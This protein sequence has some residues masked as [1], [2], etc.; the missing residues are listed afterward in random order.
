[1]NVDNDKTPGPSKQTMQS[2]KE[3]PLPNKPQVSR[4]RPV[5][6][7]IK[8]VDERKEN[9]GPL[10]GGSN[11]MRNDDRASAGLGPMTSGTMQSDLRGSQSLSEASKGFVGTG[12]N[13][14]VAGQ[15]TAGANQSSLWSMEN[16][17]GILGLSKLNNDNAKQPS[18]VDANAM[19]SKPSFVN[20][21]PGMQAP[22]NSAQG[23]QIASKPSVENTGL[24][25]HVPAGSTSNQKLTGPQVNGFKVSTSEP[26]PKVPMLI[27]ITFPKFLQTKNDSMIQIMV[28]DDK[29][30]DKGKAVMPQ[31][32]NFKPV[33]NFTG[34]TG[35]ILTASEEFF[36]DKEDRTDR[37]NEGK[38]I[39]Q[40]AKFIDSS[41][42]KL[43]YQMSDFV[44]DNTQTPEQQLKSDHVK[45]TAKSDRIDNKENSA[46][47]I[48][49]EETAPPKLM[50]EDR[51]GKDNKNKDDSET[52]LKIAK[53]LMHNGDPASNDD[54]FIPKQL[55]SDGTSTY[56]RERNEPDYGFTD[57][58]IKVNNTYKSHDSGVLSTR[59]ITN[60]G[61]LSAI[62]SPIFGNNTSV[63]FKPDNFKLL[64]TNSSVLVPMH[65]LNVSAGNQ[66]LKLPNPADDKQSFRPEF[67]NESSP[68]DA[69]MSYENS[70][71]QKLENS[72][73][74]G[75][76]A[77]FRPEVESNDIGSK[78]FTTIN[79]K[80][81][82]KEDKNSTLINRIV[83]NTNPGGTSNEKSGPL[84]NGDKLEPVEEKHL[85]S[86]EFRGHKLENDWEIKP[87]SSEDYGHK[88]K[89]ESHDEYQN[90]INNKKF[91]KLIDFAEIADHSIEKK[92]QHHGRVSDSKFVNLE[93]QILAQEDNIFKKRPVAK[94]TQQERKLKESKGLNGPGSNSERDEG[95][96]EKSKEAEFSFSS[97]IEEHHKLGLHGVELLPDRNGGK[98]T[99]D[100][101]KSG[102]NHEEESSEFISPKEEKESKSVGSSPTKM[103]D[104]KLSD[105]VERGTHFAATSQKTLGRLDNE[106]LGSQEVVGLEN[107][108]RS[109]HGV[110]K[111]NSGNNRLYLP[112]NASSKQNGPSAKLEQEGVQAS[113]SKSTEHRE[114]VGYQVQSNDVG[115]VD[116]ISGGKSEGREQSK[117][118]VSDRQNHNSPAGN[119]PAQDGAK[120]NND[121]TEFNSPE[122]NNQKSFDSGSEKET[123]PNEHQS[124][125]NSLAYDKTSNVAENDVEG[126]V[127]KV[128]QKL[129]SFHNVRVS[130]NK[131]VKENDNITT[132]SVGNGFIN[133]RY[134]KP[135]L[136]RND[137]QEAKFYSHVSASNSEFAKPV[138]NR[139][140]S[141]IN[142][143]I[144]DTEDLIAS[145]KG[146]PNIENEERTGLRE[147]QES[148]LV[149]V[150]GEKSGHKSFSPVI[151][152][153]N[154]H[155]F[156]IQI[157]PTHSFH[158][159]SSDKKEKQNDSGEHDTNSQSSSENVVL[160]RQAMGKSKSVKFLNKEKDSNSHES[161]FSSTKERTSKSQEG[162]TASQDDSQIDL[163]KA[164]AQ[165]NEKGIKASQATSDRTVS[166]FNDGQ[167]NT[168]TLSNADTNTKEPTL[169][170]YKGSSSSGNNGHSILEFTNK[171]LKSQGV[172]QALESNK[173][174]GENQFGTG[175][176]EH[177]GFH[178]RQESDKFTKLSGSETSQNGLNI[179]THGTENSYDKSLKT[180]G[181]TN[182]PSSQHSGNIQVSKS[183]QDHSGSN[184][185]GRTGSRI[186]TKYDDSDFIKDS[187]NNELEKTSN[188]DHKASNMLTREGFSRGRSKDIGTESKHG[189]NTAGHLLTGSL[190]ENH[191]SLESRKGKTDAKTDMP[192]CKSNCPKSGSSIFNP[193]KIARGEASVVGLNLQAGFD[194]FLGFS[195]MKSG[196]ALSKTDEVGA[197]SRQHLE[198]RVNEHSSFGNE[199]IFIPQEGK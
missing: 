23:M 157:R 120:K 171:Q 188:E 102:R 165:S 104:Q 6:P 71:H 68:Q 114:Q 36:N 47:L 26:T 7:E 139:F 154:D 155:H 87:A 25:M 83:T 8:K 58:T 130:G 1:M 193:E 195:K 88:N 150:H 94:M 136:H 117:F 127:D 183:Q 105:S 76:P 198:G 142:P 138:V 53:K 166:R 12:Q 153:E 106:H 192:I 39:E 177:L 55:E 54:Y 133:I 61:N 99:E 16:V 124:N 90:V 24:G 191:H 194:R 173:G 170:P 67:H 11:Y 95:N 92:K 73:K 176:Y 19:A 121:G 184:L 168:K 100:N 37:L 69:L 147:T 143:G 160:D 72:L 97:S 38:S 116:K 40:P 182:L 162:T 151:D 110:T 163:M 103:V 45:G 41:D 70:P 141:Q 158:G 101:L 125:Q 20:A 179:G 180:E 75:S 126:I 57:E 93:K 190:D 123:R 79:E 43:G 22:V 131:D 30:D 48:A 52:Y 185:Q 2:M 146:H 175:R 109:S 161:D 140:H 112:D 167:R 108:D 80:I 42:S 197:D 46:R 178:G 27:N 111:E 32:S 34:K 113:K 50:F 81:A 4:P 164:N 86:Q 122:T 74:D 189:S 60:K 91:V 145:H 169:Q 14:P 21:G 132:I 49:S 148:G 119:I 172:S 56:A 17:P 18:R 13:S 3:E 28:G 135:E 196:P 15:S 137:K 115:N 77:S 51:K 84:A 78:E 89:Q 118:L 5:L 107:H 65:Q 59:N 144:K 82:L 98:S 85:T 63:N 187:P 44:N 129:P 199:L 149:S 66:T 64:T 134:E 31:E 10:T 181:N 9:N 35:H 29:P 128:S 156:V 186:L 152:K 62:G 33:V 174:P 159:S 96:M